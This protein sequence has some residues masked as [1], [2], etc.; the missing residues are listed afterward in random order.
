M[1]KHR[2]SGTHRFL[3]A[4]G[5][6][7]HPLRPDLDDRPELTAEINAVRA[8]F[9][10]GTGDP[11]DTTLGY[12]EV[13]GFGPDLPAGELKA[14]LRSFLT[15]RART[16]D[17][18]VVFYYTGHGEV[19]DSGE[20]L[21]PFTD[22]TSDV[23]G[24]AIPAGELARW[25]LVG[26]PV[27]RL[28][29]VL[30]TCHAGAASSDVGA[31][32]ITALG[33]LRG[34]A[35]RPQY[36]ILAA[37]R[38]REQ[39]YSGAFTQ[40]LT[41][42]VRHRA[43]GGHEP[44]H[45][46]LDAVVEVINADPATPGSQHAQLFSQG[47]ATAEFL[48]N[49]RYNQRLHGLDL[50]TQLDREQR[51][52]RDREFAEHVLPRAM[53]LDA[54]R[55]GLWLFTGRHAALRDL[56]S[57]LRDRDGVVRV[58]TGD[59]GSG[60]S[61][62]LSRL[63]VLATPEHLRKVPRPDELPPDTLPPRQSI[64][65]II[66]ARGKT[67]D[68]VLHALASA[69]GVE[70]ERPGDLLAALSDRTHPFV[71]VIDALDEATDPDHLAG[72]VLAPL[73]RGAP[74]A[75]LRLALGTRRHLIDRL[76]GPIEVLNLDSDTYADPASVRAYVRRCLLDLVDGSSYQD[77]PSQTVE[78]VAAAV[79][80]A[81]GRSFLVAQITSRSLAMR[82]DVANPYNAA[83]R[84]GLPRLAADAMRLDLDQRL[85]PLATQ[86]RD[87][88]RPLAY[89]LGS[90]LPWEDIWAPMASALAGRTYTNADLDWLVREAGFYV[91]EA[92]DGA[93]SVYRL[94]HEALAEHLRSETNEQDTH[95]A[96]VKFLIQRTPRGERGRLWA[97][98][99]PY[100]RTHL[101]S[102][103]AAA[104]RLDELVLDP[105]YLLHAD[106]APLLAN[107]PALTSAEPRGAARAWR[108]AIRHLR[109]KPADE[110]GAYLELAARCYDA[111]VLAH[112]IGLQQLPRP[113][114][115]SWAQWVRLGRDAVVLGHSDRVRDIALG[116]LDERPVV[117]SGSDDG[118][119]RVWDLATGT[120]IGRPF[121]GHNGSVRTVCA[122]F[123]GER[124]V[125]VSGGEDSTV[126]IW[127]LATGT[128][129]A[130]P[131]T[132]HR[133]TV[134]ATAIADI[135]DRPI[136][137]TGSLDDSVRLWDLATGEAIGNPLHGH[138]GGVIA[139]AAA[140]STWRPV[141]ASADSDGK[142]CVW[143]LISGTA[144]RTQST[145]PRFPILDMIVSEVGQHAVLTIAC[146]S[147]GGRSI[148]RSWDLTTGAPVGPTISLTGFVPRSLTADKHDGRPILVSGHDDGTIR[149]WDL[150][151]G[152]PVRQPFNG[153]V[154][155]VYALTVGRLDDLPVVVSGS[156][157]RTVRVWDLA[158]N[159]HDTT[160]RGTHLRGVQT[161]S[162]GSLNNHPVIATG[163]EDRT[164][165]V[166]DST[167]GEALGEP[168]VGHTAT[169]RAVAVGNADGQ[170]V[171]VSG[172]DDGTVSVW[173]ALTY[174][175][176]SALPLIH[177]ASVRAVALMTLNGRATVVSGAQDGSIRIWDLWS[178]RQC[179]DPVAGYLYPILIV[180]LGR[181]KGRLVT[182]DG[183]R[184]HLV[185]GPSYFHRAF[186]PAPDTVG[187]TPPPFFTTID[188][189]TVIVA[190]NHQ[191][192]IHKVT[193]TA[194]KHGMVRLRPQLRTRVIDSGAGK[195]PITALA[196]YPN[197]PL[198]VARGDTLEFAGQ[199]IQ[200]DAEITAITQP[201]PNNAVVAT[202]LGLVCLNLTAGRHDRQ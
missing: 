165:R 51:H 193:L 38:P 31:R 23:V 146:G 150:T 73:V 74:H 41:R 149:V 137:V 145:D 83:W 163:G 47:E 82:S 19:D 188:G 153:H 187:N 109:T 64:D 77:A 35:N 105:T 97:R 175:K 12:R 183:D 138:A 199:Q 190:C 120:P 46:A 140:T 104:G 179:A 17:D 108:R 180:A 101:A 192:D 4:T 103:A 32:A 15:N 118:T 127:D 129:I 151:D 155:N 14:Q 126:W 94:Y 63:T 49:P 113:W 93:R 33:R 65:I 90:G 125:A 91:V 135:E 76:G 110:H 66:H 70:A 200:L 128:P 59:P 75:K 84:A 142:V 28:L 197:H 157:D 60:K 62:V 170:P 36:A 152:T 6:T 30:D 85:G 58:V 69:A 27:Q 133:R 181:S 202:K 78:A 122:G 96:V 22:S 143:D 50:R 147:A 174:T 115:T 178:G 25:L 89:A 156:E 7:R 40:A 5:T 166:W 168:Y 132:G 191:G 131:I 154:G 67:G 158:S 194:P 196:H 2:D 88:L 195:L 13:P 44:R 20:F 123:L 8:L 159:Q 18:Y 130:A 201:A 124:S 184:E 112:H 182:L 80:E 79:A 29:I 9:V 189:E 186:R 119:A 162:S 53:G 16:S 100:V 134:R 34:M 24:T 10:T 3:I 37:T 39:A 161:I 86:A 160:S 177:G 139:V 167:T 99:H 61:S 57:W 111:E 171:V 164:V 68:Q 176:L 173:N 169:V 114:H 95:R 107:L 117:L 1:H 148:I 136:L 144:I 141:A 55:E 42:A 43:T 52:E 21:L 54:P 11:D 185:W 98:A 106:R 26:T 81:A 198:L 121:T 72:R 48:P 56:S 172:G 102:H 45:L 71:A 92:L 87:L 116:T